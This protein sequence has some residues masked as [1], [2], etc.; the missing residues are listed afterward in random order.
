MKV[1]IRQNNCRNK[2]VW[3]IDVAIDHVL[4]EHFQVYLSAYVDEME[5]IYFLVVTDSDGAFYDSVPRSFDK[6]GQLNM[7]TVRSLV[8][9]LFPASLQNPWPRKKK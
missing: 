8:L 9:G 2:I 4:A 6:R 7:A 5:T 1:N 3:E